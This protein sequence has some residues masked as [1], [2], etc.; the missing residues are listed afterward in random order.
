MVYCLIEPS[1]HNSILEA[2][3]VEPS[4]QLPASKRALPQLSM[5]PR[6][7]QRGGLIKQR[8]GRVGGYPRLH[9]LLLWYTLVYLS[10]WFSV[11]RPAWKKPGSDERTR[12]P[13]MKPIRKEGVG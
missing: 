5:T 12:S 11:R 9:L 4:A 7:A 8:S 3:S 1:A 10:F 6:D 2:D 13:R